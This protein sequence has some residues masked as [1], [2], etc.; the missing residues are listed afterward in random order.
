MPLTAKA[1]RGQFTR[2]GV[3][4]KPFFQCPLPVRQLLLGSGPVSNLLE[5]GFSRTRSG[6][7][8]TTGDSRTGLLCGL[9]AYTIWGFIPLYFHAV[10]DVPPLTVLCHRVVWSALF[11]ALLVS[12]RRDWEP[13]WPVLRR[14][15]SLALLAAGAVLIALNWLIFIYAVTT[16]QLL[17]ASLGYFINPLLSIALGMVFLRERLR[18]WQWLAVAVAALGVANLALRGSGFPWIA[19]TL[20]GSFGFYGLVRKTVDINSLHGLMI[21]SALLFPMAVAMLFILPGG[22]HLGTLGLLSLS[23]VITAVPLLFFGAALRRLKLSTMGF[24]QYIGPTLQFLVAVCLFREPLDRARLSS[25]AICWIA[26]AIY[27]AD[28]LLKG[29]FQPV[30]DEPE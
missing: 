7:R 16:R 2:R 13:I 14:R 24:L 22:F 29:R 19:L 26:I 25:F 11:M 6:A 17:Q 30:A 3:S 21:E 23:G 8:S 20:A 27:V 18:Q 1:S 9:G 28:S 15:R 5:T 10:S 4:Q 12:L